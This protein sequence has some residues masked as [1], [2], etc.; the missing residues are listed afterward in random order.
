LKRV[1]CILASALL[2]LIFPTTAQ[3]ATVTTVDFTAAPKGT[4]FLT[5][6]QEPTC[7]VSGVDVTCTSYELRGVGAAKA[8]ALLW[9]TWTALIECRDAADQ[10]VDVSVNDEADGDIRQLE[11]KGRLVVPELAP[12]S[13]WPETQFPEIATCPSE[14]WSPSVV[15]G[16]ITLTDFTY[17]LTF[18]CFTRPAITVTGP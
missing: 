10:V 18:T 14:E 2:A 3:A 1:G 8:E 5:G 12:P 16:S 13:G 17:T 7:T 9:V 11:A 6:A 4:H 15:P